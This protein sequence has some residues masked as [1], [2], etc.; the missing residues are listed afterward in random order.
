MTIAYT[1][2]YRFLP[3]QWKSPIPPLD[4]ED[5]LRTLEYRR[6]IAPFL[7]D[8]LD[9]LNTWRFFIKYGVMPM[10]IVLLILGWIGLSAFT[11]LLTIVGI[12]SF[13][14]WIRIRVYQRTAAIIQ[15]VIDVVLNDSFG[16]Q[17]P[18]ILEEE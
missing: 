18:K 8:W 3:K 15:L 11:I 7:K 14:I 17:L 10:I 1:F 2:Q 13:F 6:I 5:M 4:T 9:V 12:A 16:I